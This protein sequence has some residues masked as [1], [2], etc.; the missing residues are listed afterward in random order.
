M[1]RKR[2]DARSAVVFARRKKPQRWLPKETKR[3]GELP[4]KSGGG[5]RWWRGLRTRRNVVADERRV[6][7]PRPRRA[8]MFIDDAA[9]A[10][11][12]CRLTTRR[13]LARGAS[14]TKWRRRPGPIQGRLRG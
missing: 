8:V 13:S 3:S 14:A 5:L 11:R 7:P 1:R 9:V 2:P 6:G 12:T 4:S 10:T